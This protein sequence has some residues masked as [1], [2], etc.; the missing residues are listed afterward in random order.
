MSTSKNQLFVQLEEFLA[1]FW[2]EVC[3]I[4]VSDAAY[5]EGNW[6]VDRT[7]LTNILNEIQS[8]FHP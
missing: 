5:L 6:V 1:V 7:A 4:S 2:R 3:R 8:N